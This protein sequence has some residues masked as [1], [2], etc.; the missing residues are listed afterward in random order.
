MR[1]AIWIVVWL[2]AGFFMRITVTDVT[3]KKYPDLGERAEKAFQW[4]IA[5]EVLVA[6]ACIAGYYLTAS[7]PP[8]PP[9]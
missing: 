3:A 2:V 6:G 1:Y 7:K 8:S 9:S 5:G 4:S